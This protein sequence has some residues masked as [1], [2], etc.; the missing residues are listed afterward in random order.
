MLGLFII[1][2]SILAGKC[3]YEL[4]FCLLKKVRGENDTNKTISVI[5]AVILSL[6]FAKLLV[7]YCH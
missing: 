5:L 6:G 7:G 2:T 3:I 1:L 4:C